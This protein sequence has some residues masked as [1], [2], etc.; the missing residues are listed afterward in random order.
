MFPKLK[1]VV[2]E[3]GGKISENEMA[4]MNAKV[5]SDKKDPRYVTREF[6][7]KKGLIK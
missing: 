5:D 3:L 4:G 7:K 1:E 6:L 2:N